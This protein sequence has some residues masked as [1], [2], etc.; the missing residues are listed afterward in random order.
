MAMAG[1][2]TDSSVDRSVVLSGATMGTTYS[3]KIADPPATLDSNELNRAIAVLLEQVN[4]QM[5]TY[6]QD[7]ELSRFNRSRSTDWVSVSS[8]LVEVVEHALS[9]SRLTSGAFDITV[10]PLVNLWGFGPPEQDQTLPSDDRIQ[11]ALSYVGYRHVHT[12]RSPPGLK[13]D[14]PEL[15]LNLSAIAK[16]YGVD[17]LA[18]HLESSGIENYLVE[19][20]GELRGKGHNPRRQPWRVAVEKPIA[21]TRAIQRIIALTDRSIATSGDYRNYFEHNETR[22]S[23]TI[24]PRTGSPVRHGL[25]SVTVMSPTATHAD[26]MATAFMVLGPDKGYEL[27]LQ[28][29]LPALFVVKNGKGFVEK[30]TPEFEQ[31]L[32]D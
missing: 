7:S 6:V 30:R 23:H 31:L 28:Q 13:K 12:R 29:E 5:S 17:K 2:G 18:E 26:A 1:C 32:V 14:R 8:S 3:I 19:I 27:A 4:D 11:E 21:E 10:G 22:F 9:V 24:D 20:G 25:A 16:G 15:Y